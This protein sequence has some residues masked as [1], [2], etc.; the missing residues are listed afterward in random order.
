MKDLLTFIGAM[1]IGIGLILYNAFSF[2]YVT[3]I[4]YQ[5]FII[6][7][8]KDLPNFTWTHFA[9]FNLF[10][11]AMMPKHVNHIQSKFED[12][13]AKWIGILCGPWILLLSMWLIKTIIL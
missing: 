8:F 13:W 9:G 4:A 11:V 3:E 7:H 10:I 12:E 2:A 1:A 5:L 6:P